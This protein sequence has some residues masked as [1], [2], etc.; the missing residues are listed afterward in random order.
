MQNFKKPNRTSAYLINYKTARILYQEAFPIRRPPD[1]LTGRYNLPDLRSYGISG[2]V[3]K[4]KNF[5]STIKYRN[6]F[7]GQYKILSWIVKTNV[8]NFLIFF[9]NIIKKSKNFTRLK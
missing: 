1:G 7:F 8:I 6:T 2:S 3:V 9:I 5:S 4:L